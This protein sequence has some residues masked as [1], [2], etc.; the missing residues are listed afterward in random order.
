MKR[1]DYIFD[2]YKDKRTVFQLADIAMLFPKSE[3]KFLANK[4]GL[5]LFKCKLFEP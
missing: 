2:I 4:M 3:N 1:V 5:A